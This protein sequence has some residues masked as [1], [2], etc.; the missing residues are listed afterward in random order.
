RPPPAPGELGPLRPAAAIH[1][2]LRRRRRAGVR[3]ARG[4]AH[5]RRALPPPHRGR[6]APLDR[7][8]RALGGRRP[9]GPSGR[10]ETGLADVPRDA[11][12]PAPETPTADWPPEVPAARP[13]LTWAVRAGLVVIAAGLT[14]LFAVALWLDPYGPGGVPLAM[15]THRQLGLPPCNF[16]RLTGLPC[17]SCGMTTSFAL[18]VRGDVG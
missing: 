16:Q 17:P 3:A 6:P 18:L 7:T 15:G 11:M 13:A 9:G 12:V 2:R 5:R 10:R 14:A 1:P 8:G 4:R